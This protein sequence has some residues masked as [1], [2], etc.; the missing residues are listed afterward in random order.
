MSFDQSTLS[1]ACTGL[2]KYSQDSIVVTQRPGG[3]E[4]SKPPVNDRSS[5]PIK[6]AP[7]SVLNDVH[8]YQLP[9]K[10]LATRRSAAFDVLDMHWLNTIFTLFIMFHSFIDVLSLYFS[11][12]NLPIVEVHLNCL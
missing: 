5:P 6:L 9:T 7:V 3:I 12:Q 1:Q 10:D 4:Y 8:G 2:A 11:N